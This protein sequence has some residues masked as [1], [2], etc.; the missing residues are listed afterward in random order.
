MNELIIITFND[1]AARLAVGLTVNRIQFY[2]T[3][4][5]GGMTKI[6]MNCKEDFDAALAILKANNGVKELVLEDMRL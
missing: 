2:S 6:E 1:R 4:S 5:E 3:P